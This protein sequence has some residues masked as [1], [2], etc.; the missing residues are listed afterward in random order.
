MSLMFDAVLDKLCSFFQQN[1]EMLR[2]VGAILINR[3]MNGRISLILDAGVEENTSAQPALELIRRALPTE[4]SPHILN[5]ENI[6]LFEDHIE[7]IKNGLP[8]FALEAGT[9]DITCVDRVVSGVEWSRIAP[10]AVDQPPRIVFFSIKGGVGRSTALAVTAHALAE[11][12]RKVLV[13]DLDLESP[14]LSSAL[15][16]EDRRPTYGIV[17]WL[18]EDLV[19]NGEAVFEEMVASSSLSH[20][21][22]IRVVPAHGRYAG[23]YLSKLGRIWMPKRCANGTQET[24]TAR[25]RRLLTLLEINERPDVVLIDSRAGIDDIAS[26]CVTSLG[27]RRVLLFAIDGAQTWQGYSVLFEH[28]QRYALTQKLGNTLQIVAGLVP[29]VNSKEYMKNLCEHAY[30]LFMQ[31]LYEEI[32]PTEMMDEYFNFEET[33]QSAPHYPWGVLWN[34]SYEALYSLHGTVNL[35]EP[36]RAEL[37]FGELLNGIKTLLDE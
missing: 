11:E 25:L 3:D 13:L 34:R 35:I 17:D 19:D 28:W 31:Y 14:G 32:P 10:L 24:W 36:N 5:G 7:A 20:N 12:G 9:L 1:E 21:G 16:P 23:E 6:I 33:D 37:A 30:T 18:V 2:S 26:A 4:L 22:D 27:A 15:L 8:T 29:E